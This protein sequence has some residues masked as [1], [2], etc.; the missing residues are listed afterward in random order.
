MKT[1][2]QKHKHKTGWSQRTDDAWNFTLIST[3]LRSVRELITPWSL[4]TIK[5]LLTIHPQGESHSLEAVSPLWP[6]LPRKAIKAP[7]V[8]HPKL[9]SMLL[10]GNSE[11]RLSFGNRSNVPN[12]R[13]TSKQKPASPYSGPLAYSPGSPGGTRHS[14]CPP[15]CL[16]ASDENSVIAHVLSDTWQEW[17]VMLRDVRVAPYCSIT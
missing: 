6:P 10:F 4:N 8:L 13:V 7:L 5:L 16:S 1:G 3:N 12:K 9:F 14:F 15:G 2:T 17:K 11:Q